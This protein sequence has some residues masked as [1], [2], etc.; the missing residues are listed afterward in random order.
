MPLV[1]RQHI[2]VAVVLAAGLGM[3]SGAQA[4]D[5]KHV[6]GVITDHGNQGTLTVQTDGSSTPLTVVVDES[7]QVRRS[8]M[9]K[10]KKLS[11]DV[12]KPGLR[13]KADGT[14]EN[15]GIFIARR[16]TATKEDLRT[17]RAIEGGLSP[18]DK[19]VAAN[20]QRL[21][22]QEQQI[23]A[24]EQRVAATAGA[25]NA[26]ISNLDDYTVIQ[27]MTVYFA[28]GK[29]GIAPKYK[30]ELQQFAAQVKDVKGAVVQVQGYA[31]AVGPD[32]IN[33]PLSRRR[34]DAVTAVLQQSGVTPT[35]L[36]YPAA[37]GTTGQVASNKTAEGQSQNRRVVVKLLQNKGVAG[38]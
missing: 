5:D 21:K 22:E 15:S 4:D 30:T 38:R 23:A 34:A 29:A 7:T 20:V 37:M 14:Y 33:Q 18:V 28:N 35:D 1:F 11:S 8:G 13:I 32:A 6:S 16:I 36:A 27:S 25:F 3:S 31:S 2:V 9:L 12:L 17:A 10:S 19:Q 26:R 24:N